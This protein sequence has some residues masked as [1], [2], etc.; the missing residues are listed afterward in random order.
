VKMYIR[1]VDDA[2]M[3]EIAPSQAV[4][5]KSALALK[6]VTREQV[7]AARRQTEQQERA[8]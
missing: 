8:A 4:N 2:E 5:V 3:I 7:E 1:G 6:L